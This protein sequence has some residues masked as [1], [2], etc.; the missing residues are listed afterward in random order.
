MTLQIRRVVTGHDSEGRAVVLHDGIAPNVVSRRDKHSSCVVWS[1]DRFPSD[2]SAAA[3]AA[4]AR[5]VVGTDPGGSV[6]RI[7]RYEPGVASR[8]HRTESL[9]YAVIIS[10]EIEMTL[11]TETVTLRQ[12][13]VLVQRGTIHDWINRG[14]EPCIIAFV[15]LAAEPVVAGDR[16][17][18]A[19]G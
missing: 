10:G 9:D 11:D 17:L 14:T 4:G 3:E 19:T 7:G 6:F 18:S 2:N 16:V 5:A 13:D 8:N 12:G 1:T 15:L